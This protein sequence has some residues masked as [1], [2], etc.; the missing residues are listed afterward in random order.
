MRGCQIMAGHTR[1][2]RPQ[3]ILLFV[4]GLRVG[5][6]DLQWSPVSHDLSLFDPHAPIAD[7]KKRRMIMRDK[8]RRPAGLLKPA[9]AL[10]ALAEKIGVSDSQ[11]F[12]DYLYVRRLGRCDCKCQTHM[13]SCRIG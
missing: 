9:E 13:H 6:H 12:I 7:P 11:Y 4:Y 5:R 1:F 8:D 10:K 3:A 2:R